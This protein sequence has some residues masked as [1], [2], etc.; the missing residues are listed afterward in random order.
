MG[1]RRRSVWWGDSR[2]VVLLIPNKPRDV[3]VRLKFW[4]VESFS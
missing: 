1:S 2:Q 4:V 3:S